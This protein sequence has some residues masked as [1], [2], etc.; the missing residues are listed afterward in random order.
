MSNN[1]YQTPKALATFVTDIMMCMLD[2]IR[3][4]ECDEY[5]YAADQR[6]NMAKHKMLVHKMGDRKWKCE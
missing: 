5:G 4:F 3:E 1:H 6:G 2:K